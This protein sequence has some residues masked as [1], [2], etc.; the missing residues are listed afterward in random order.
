MALTFA[1]KW[2]WDYQK[3]AIQLFEKKPFDYTAARNLLKSAIADD[4]RGCGLKNEIDTGAARVVKGPHKTPGGDTRFHMS[5]HCKTMRSIY[6]V[7]MS[8]NGNYSGMG[9]EPVSGTDPKTGH[10]KDDRAAPSVPN[11]ASL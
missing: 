1:F 11:C 2:N 5:V 6:H 7:Y 9:Q 4:I 10:V 8:K 3:D